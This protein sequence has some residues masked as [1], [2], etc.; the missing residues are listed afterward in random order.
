MNNILT[1]IR[2]RGD[3]TF[4]QVPFN[5]SDAVALALLVGINLTDLFTGRERLE[6]VAEAFLD[7]GKRDERDNQMDEKVEMIKAMAHSARFR[8]ILLENFVMEI[9]MVTEMTF[10]G[11]TA[12]TSPRRAY[13]IFRGTDGTL[14]SWKENFNFACEMPSPGQRRSLAYLTEV[15]RH[16]FVHAEVI[17][18]SK[19]GGLAVYSAMSIPARMQRRIDRVVCFDGPGFMRDV[20]EDKAY[21]AI[22]DRIMAYSPQYCVVGNLLKVPFP[23]ANVACEGKFFFQHDLFNWNLTATCPQTGEAE[24][25]DGRRLAEKLNEWLEGIPEEERKGY[26]DEL[27]DAF[28]KNNVMHITDLEHLG[29]KQMFG[30]VA[31]A[32][33]ISPENR[34]LVWIVLREI[35]GN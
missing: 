17:G 22:A 28:A 19:G 33:K 23:H 27:F 1:Y 5:D 14:L 4:R 2:F 16:P 13:V 30:I 35:I 12:Y 18:H 29:V 24:D 9:D 31:S 25:P 3:L 7:H 20:S 26:V 10:Y 6:T 11:L 15:L 32:V 34:D 21:L 8:D